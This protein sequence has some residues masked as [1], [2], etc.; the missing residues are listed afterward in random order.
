MVQVYIITTIQVLKVYKILF[1]TLK[2]K[3]T[4]FTYVTCIL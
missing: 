3:I 4:N 1:L 2:N